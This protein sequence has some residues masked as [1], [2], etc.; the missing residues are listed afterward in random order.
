MSEAVGGEFQSHGNQSKGY[1][2]FT[3]TVPFDDCL[4]TSLAYC[5]EKMNLKMHQ[6]EASGEAG[7]ENWFSSGS[8]KV[9][10]PGGTHLLIR[11]RMLLK[12]KFSQGS[13]HLRFIGQGKWAV[14]LKAFLTVPTISMILCPRY[15]LSLRVSFIPSLP[16]FKAPSLL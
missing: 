10:S 8:N 16:I 4:I 6:W 9:I 3:N 11:R 14:R 15:I 7:Y 1:K 13:F 5:K 12:S 2:R